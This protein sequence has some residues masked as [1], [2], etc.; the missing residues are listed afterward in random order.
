MCPLL[1]TRKRGLRHPGIAVWE[2]AGAQ[3]VEAALVIILLLALLIGIVWMSRA[4]NLH[5]T[6]TR[7]AREGARFAAAPSCAT[8]GNLYPSDTEVRQRVDDALLASGVDPANVTNFAINRAVV[9]NPGSTPQV[10]GVA[11]SF[12]YPIQLVVPF[13][14]V[15][16]SSVN[17]ATQVQMREE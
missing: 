16:L 15:H 5:E 6:M 3:L 12:N 2:D 8:C 14:S 17:L 4:Y 13:T 10:T 7:A 9:L 1:K 11:V